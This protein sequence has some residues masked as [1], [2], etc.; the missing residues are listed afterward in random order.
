MDGNMILKLKHWL[1]AK[2]QQHGAVRSTNIRLFSAVLVTGLVSAACA[3]TSTGV[4]TPSAPVATGSPEV[5]EVYSPFPSMTPVPTL[6]ETATNTPSAP[7][8]TPTSALAVACN[9]AP[10]SVS[11]DG[12]WVFCD[13]KDANGF[14][15]PYVVSMDGKRWDVSYKKLAGTA[16]IYDDHKVLTWMP[17]DH[18]VYVMTHLS[19]TGIGRF[20]YAGSDVWRMDLASGEVK[21]LLP[22]YTFDSNF[23]DLTVSPDGRRLA[24]VDQWM[25]PLMLDVFNLP[26]DSKTEIKLA[27]TKVGNTAPVT[28]GELFLTPDGKKIIY[29]MI[30][31]SASNQCAYV[32]SIQIMDLGS[33]LTQTVIGNQSISMCNGEPEEYHVLKVDNQQIIL[34][35]HGAI[36]RYDIS[37]NTLELQASFTATP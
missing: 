6:T 16:P 28:A 1:R 18:Y 37:A 35:Q 29:K 23:Y 36:W 19:A 31:V 24:V 2:F 20:F 10:A 22:V 30:S 9:G 12:K 32:Y 4:L 26:E 8:P 7:S 3:F 15:I 33:Q 27:D 17:D 11:L 34:E 25:T 5:S 14:S 13:A 21:D